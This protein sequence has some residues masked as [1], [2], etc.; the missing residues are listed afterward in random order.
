MVTETND[1]DGNV[2]L[3]G[4]H[5]DMGCY[6]VQ[7]VINPYDGDHDGLPDR[8]EWDHFGGNTTA[9]RD[10]D[11]DGQSNGDEYIAGTIP[12][13]EASYFSVTVGDAGE[14]G[15]AS[16]VIEWTSVSGRVYTVYWAP[17]LTEGFQPFSDVLRYPQNSYTD[18]VHSAQSFGFYVVKVGLD[19][20]AD[21]D[22][23][24]L[25]DQWEILYFSD[26]VA[27]AA[28][29]DSDGDGQSNL[30]EYITGM[31]P[32]NAASRFSVQSPSPNLLQWESVSGRVYSVYWSTNL[33][34]GF[35]PLETNLPWTASSFTDTVH[36]AESRGFYKID[37]RLE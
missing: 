1:L 28:G 12:T 4:S 30:D 22:M 24:G 17:S 37:V 3:I 32:T 2:R 25:P 11:S 15:A 33:L 16:F 8:W 18:T 35:Q 20:E 10:L 6:E 13:N 26:P 23:D 5:V 21:S 34:D 27:A 36:G 7:T 19:G 9:L 31:N 29:V 14:A